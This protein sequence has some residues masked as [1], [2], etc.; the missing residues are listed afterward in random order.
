[1]G[2]WLRLDQHRFAGG[3]APRNVHL[4]RDI[5]LIGQGCANATALLPLAEAQLGLA[6]GDRLA[7]PAARR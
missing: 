2:G 1:M 3:P 5:E 6:L 4:E 7:G